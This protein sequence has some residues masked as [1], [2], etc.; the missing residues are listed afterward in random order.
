MC[1]EV[2]KVTLKCPTRK[3]LIINIL[4][5]LESYSTLPFSLN[6][7][8]LILHKYHRHFNDNSIAASIVSYIFSDDFK[9]SLHLIF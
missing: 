8:R 2:V 9:Y 1:S 7:R 4:D 6:V 5:G 3:Y